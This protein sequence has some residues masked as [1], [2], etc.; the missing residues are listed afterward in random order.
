MTPRSYHIVWNNSRNKPF[1]FRKKDWNPPKVDKVNWRFEFTRRIL[2]KLLFRTSNEQSSSTNRSF[3][4]IFTIQNYAFNNKFVYRSTFERCIK[5]VH[6]MHFVWSYYG[7][8][9]REI[10]RR[11][12]C[13]TVTTLKLK[14]L[15]LMKLS[16]ALV[17]V[18]YHSWHTSS[19]CVSWNKLTEMCYYIKTIR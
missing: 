7:N 3:Y 8:N 2:A 12:I 13:E 4:R 18:I 9:V 15:K 14:A 10:T 5:T 17:L 6:R 11:E 19:H 16:L 1:F